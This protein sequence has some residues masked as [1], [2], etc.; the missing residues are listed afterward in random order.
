M[1]KRGLHILILL[2]ILLITISCSKNEEIIKDAL[3]EIDDLSLILRVDESYNLNIAEDII[4]NP[5][6]NDIVLV[7]D[8]KKKITGLSK[9]STKATIYKKD[10]LKI[11]K[12][13][14]ITVTEG[15]NIELDETGE[16][17]IHNPIDTLYL[18]DTY[19]LD[20]TSKNN[21]DLIFESSN[22]EIATVDI[23]GNINIHDSGIFSIRISPTS[24]PEI[25]STIEIEIKP[26]IN[27]ERFIEKVAITEPT[28]E[29][30]TVTGYQF[31]YDYTLMG[32]LSY[33]LF[34]DLEITE[35]YIPK[36]NKNRPGKSINGNT[37]KAL[38]VTMHDTGATDKS[39]NALRHAKYWSNS[40]V[41]TSAHFATGNDGIYQL[42]PYNEIGYHAG[43]GTTES[44]KFT[45][46][47]IKAN[48]DQ[49]AKVTI[50]ND[51]YFVLNGIKS[52]I[53]APKKSNGSLCT[54]KDLPTTGINNYVD[55]NT[56]TY[57]IGSTYYNTTYN[58]LSNYGGNLNSIGIES[59]VNQGSNIYLTW[60]M[61]AKLIGEEI[62]PKNNLQPKDIK[63][64]NTF[65]GKNC[66]QTMREANQWENFIKMCEIEYLMATH[67][68]GWSLTL[69]CNSPYI[70]ENGLIKK[71]P[72]SN[73]F[74][75]FKLR[76]TNYMDYDKTFEFTAKINV[77]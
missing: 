11:S 4:I 38:Y 49:P 67:F 8:K 75:K 25:H 35:R 30:I 52:D 39:A 64:H 61:T 76:M 26:Y 32:S 55:T 19:K 60:A 68:S 12:T 17:E 5:H 20:I 73:S 1:F 40:G 43:D 7:N 36:N 2:F 27:P 71:L 41:T 69:E 42:L 63:Q 21:L 72:N 50:S 70:D 58:T 6:N 66:P 15:L 37:F 13:I 34:D 14:N 10:N 31:S 56:G 74:I 47:K 48:N 62:L 28:I 3:A 22:P 23:N 54:N 46:T 29:N 53:K 51:G 24:K 65:S 16:I 18:D 57:W 33:Y 9:G 45:D 44:L 59:S 77:N